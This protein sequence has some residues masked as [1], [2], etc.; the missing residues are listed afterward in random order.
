MYLWNGRVQ[1]GLSGMRLQKEKVDWVQ[2]L[3]QEGTGWDDRV[4]EKTNFIEVTS[5]N[6]E[7]LVEDNRVGKGKGAGPTN[8]YET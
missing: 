5:Q 8:W 1:E 4:E 6:D 3:V 2:R 7:V